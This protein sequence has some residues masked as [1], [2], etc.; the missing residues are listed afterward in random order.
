MIKVYIKFHEGEACEYEVPNLGCIRLADPVV[1]IKFGL[2][3]WDRVESHLVS[4]IK[5]I[6]LKFN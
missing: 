3:R 6:T 2:G 5:E 1:Q 4:A